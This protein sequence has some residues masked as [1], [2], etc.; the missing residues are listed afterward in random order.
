MGWGGKKASYQGKKERILLP[1]PFSATPLNQISKQC[2]V[3]AA[4]KMH[5]ELHFKIKKIKNK[6]KKKEKRKKERPNWLVK[7]NLTNVAFR[8]LVLD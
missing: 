6:N 4:Q 8:R 5:K 1:F 7:D 3:D 2:K